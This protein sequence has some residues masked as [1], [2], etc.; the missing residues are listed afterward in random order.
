MLADR[1]AQ[2]HNVALL[3]HGGKRGDAEQLVT[4][5]RAR[6]LGAVTICILLSSLGKHQSWKN[7]FV[8]TVYHFSTTVK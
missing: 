2:A 4:L 3:G 5:V 1:L 6:V 7:N 8:L